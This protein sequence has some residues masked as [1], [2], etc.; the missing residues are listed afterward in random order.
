MSL[1][2]SGH[3]YVPPQCLRGARCRLHVAFHGC[4]Q[5]EE[6]VGDAFYARA[7]YNGWARPIS[8][9]VLYPQATAWGGG[10][11]SSGANPRG[12]WDWWGYSG[13]AYHGKDGKQVRAVAAMLNALLGAQVLALQGDR[14]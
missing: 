9:V 6:L 1:H 11:F 10:V 14:R 12:C 3:V 2:A 13:D 8:I 5:H 7:G 4:R